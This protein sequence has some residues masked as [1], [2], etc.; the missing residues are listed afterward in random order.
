MTLDQK[1]GSICPKPLDLLCS[2]DG[3]TRCQ[4]TFLGYNCT[5]GNCYNEFKDKNGVASCKTKCD[6]SSCDESTGICE[7]NDIGMPFAVVLG[8]RLPTTFGYL[9]SWKADLPHSPD[10]VEVQDELY[11]EKIIRAMINTTIH[12]GVSLLG[13]AMMILAGLILVGG[14]GFLAYRWRIRKEMRDEVKSI[15]KQYMP[16]A[17]GEEQSEGNKSQEPV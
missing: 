5:C 12:A 1:P 9:Q 13:V 6:L 3:R 16:L 15:L 17:E 4:N 10:S 11:F 2:I 8:Q 7:A 14:L